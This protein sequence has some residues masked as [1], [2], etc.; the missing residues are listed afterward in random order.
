MVVF[1]GHSW[2]LSSAIS[3]NFFG[4]FVQIQL[5]IL[6]RAP[7]GASLQLLQALAPLMG[8][9]MGVENAKIRP[10]TAEKMPKMKDLLQDAM[11]CGT[12]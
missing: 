3:V 8:Y 11:A 4:S 2:L 6:D 7:K 5:D 10:A 1:C 9:A 12:S